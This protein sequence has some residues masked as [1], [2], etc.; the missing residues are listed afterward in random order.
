MEPGLTRLRN[1]FRTLPCF[2]RVL[3][4]A[5]CCHV[6]V[7]RRTVNKT[8]TPALRRWRNHQEPAQKARAPHHPTKQEDPGGSPAALPLPSPFRGD[9]SRHDTVDPGAAVPVQAPVTRGSAGPAAITRSLGAGVRDPGRAGPREQRRRCRGPTHPPHRG[10]PSWRPQ[11]VRVPDQAQPWRGEGLAL[12]SQPPAH[13]WGRLR[14]KHAPACS[15]RLDSH[16][17]SNSSASFS[18]SPA[19][20]TGPASEALRRRIPDPR[21][22]LWD[23]QSPTGSRKEEPRVAGAGAPE[24]ALLVNGVLPWLVPCGYASNLE[25]IVRP[26]LCFAFTLRRCL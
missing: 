21:P 11:K 24:V 7:P 6:Q 5:W 19:P 17:R 15:P 26:H 10:S 4:L 22:R 3:A 8:E 12:T 13:P 20:P 9:P 18:G 1:S 2:P 16:S 23:S 25:G 14:V